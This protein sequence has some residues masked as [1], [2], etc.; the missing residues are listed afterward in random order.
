MATADRPPFC[1]ND[2]GSGDRSREHHQEG[3]AL[4]DGVMRR[5]H[6][7]PQS[8][9]TIAALDR[10]DRD[11]CIHMLWWAPYGGPP[12][13][14]TLAEF[15]M[16]VTDMTDRFIAFVETG[17]ARSV[18]IFERTWTLERAAGMYREIC[19][20]KSNTHPRR[21]M[22]DAAATIGEGAQPIDDLEPD[23]EHIQWTLTRGG[24]WRPE[25]IA[26]DPTDRRHAPHGRT[27]SRRC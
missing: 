2:A 3:A 10:F 1:V 19:D 20:L 27:S 13:A 9:P 14:D 12:A 25:V 21:R 7:P 4:A 11:V 15:G 16:S 6:S 18:S 23:G 17:A 8:N 22:N 5:E 24:V 26:A